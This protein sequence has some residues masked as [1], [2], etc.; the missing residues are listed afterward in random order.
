[1]FIFEVKVEEKKKS[2]NHDER[3][4]KSK[5]NDEGISFKQDD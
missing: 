1:M 4:L 2:E 5:E 3:H